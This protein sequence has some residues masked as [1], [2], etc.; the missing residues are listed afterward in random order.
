MRSRVTM[1]CCA[2][3]Y[4][5]NGIRKVRLKRSWSRDWLRCCGSAAVCTC[6]TRRLCQR[7][8]AI[9][10]RNQA[11]SILQ[12]IKELAPDFQSAKDA[13]QVE[14]VLSD[15]PRYRDITG[16]VPR[17]PSQDESKWGPAIAAH[18]AKLKV[19]NVVVGYSKIPAVVDILDFEVERKVVD[20]HDE[21]IDRTSTAWC[22]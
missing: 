2:Q 12:Y 15:H 11:S 21:T 22:R 3:G 13:K 10:N 8:D 1:R 5:T 7:M 14:R 17:D 4:T 20:R 6:T 9:E 18:L 19:P 16:M